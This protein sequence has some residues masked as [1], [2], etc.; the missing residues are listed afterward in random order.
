M[1]VAFEVHQE[2][3]PARTPKRIVRAAYEVHRGDCMVELHRVADQSVDLVLIDPPYAITHAA[4]DRPLDLAALWV[5]FRRVLR[6]NAVV[7]IHC[8]TPFTG[9]VASSAPKGWL[10]Y[11]YCWLKSRPVGFIHARNRPLIAHETVLV[12]S[13]GKIADAIYSRNKMPYWPQGVVPLATPR[14]QPAAESQYRAATKLSSRPTHGPRMRTLTGYPSTVL[15][16]DTD[17]VGH[18]PTAKPISLLDFL[19]RTY[20]QSGDLVLDCCMGSGSTGVAAL[21]AGRRFIGIEKSA[22]FFRTAVE[23]LRDATDEVREGTASSRG[24][25]KRDPVDVV[26]ER[27]VELGIRARDLEGLLGGSG[28]V[29][30]LLGRRRALTLAHIR[31]LSEALG[32]S[33]DL[34]VPFY[35]LDDA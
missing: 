20:T 24:G 16:F 9:T 13:A 7:L 2:V 15:Q 21:R 8:Q 27:M 18:H 4:W 12:F 33:A 3:R 35:D 32:I 5:Q 22:P 30:E 26:V 23:R 34:L 28:R 29:S 11:D 25:R 10:K 19:I 6:P 1:S 17:H 31:I 14:M